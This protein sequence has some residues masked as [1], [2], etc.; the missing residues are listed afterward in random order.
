MQ[1]SGLVTCRGEQIKASRLVAAC[2]E[3]L[4]DQALCAPVENPR[5]LRQ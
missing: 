5:A 1:L 2:G 3:L 4:Q